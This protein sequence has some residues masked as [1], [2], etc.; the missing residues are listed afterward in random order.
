MLGA[1]DSCP[2][3]LEAM[4]A[5]GVRLPCGHVFHSMCVSRWL[6]QNLSCPYRC[7]SQS[8]LGQLRDA[9]DAGESDGNPTDEWLR[10]DIY[11]A[12]AFIS[13]TQRRAAAKAAVHHCVGGNQAQRLWRPWQKLR[14]SF[15]ESMCAMRD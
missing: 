10:E 5:G 4:S 7:S 8:C 13:S 1:S 12:C 6:Q 3:C 15:L 14:K 9:E 2:I 11:D